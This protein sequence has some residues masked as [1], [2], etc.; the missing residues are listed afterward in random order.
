ML[1]TGAIASPAQAMNRQ[2][3]NAA[4]IKRVAAKHGF[5]GA[6]TKALIILAKRESGLS[7]TPRTGSYVGLFQVPCQG[8]VAKK[9]RWKDPAINTQIALQYIKKR[10][11]TPRRALAHSYS[12]GW[13]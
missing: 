4:V 6:E 3:K 8:W 1:L 9:G 7:S 2:A 11:R 13:Y 12:H 5:R 10:Y